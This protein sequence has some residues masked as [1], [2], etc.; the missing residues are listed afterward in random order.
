ME[1]LERAAP[2]SS[3]RT[4]W[5]DRTIGL[6]PTGTVFQAAQV[7]STQVASALAGPNPELSLRTIESFDLGGAWDGT[8]RRLWKQALTSMY[9]DAPA[10]VAG[11][12]VAALGATTTTST[13]AATAYVPEN[14]ASYPKDSDLGQALRDVARLIKQRVGLQVACVDNG[15]WDMHAGVG[16]SDK[17]WMHEHLTELAQALAAFATDLGSLMD[18]VTVVTLSEFGRRVAEN[19]SGGVDHGHGNAVLLLGGGINGGKVHG[20]WPGLSEADLVDGDLAGTTDYRQ[21]L[22][23]ILTRRCGAASLAEVFP[24]LSAS[25]IGVAR[26]RA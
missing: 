8:Q 18:G 22:G 26:A 3:V 12:A 14:G 10:A 1:E 16:S 13:I 23:E 9:A 21:V 2:D 6:R 11:P 7:G 5:L 25:P 15:N 20:R 24:G 19:G 4:G 17:G